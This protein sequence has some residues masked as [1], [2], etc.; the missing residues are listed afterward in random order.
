MYVVASHC[1]ICIYA[2]ILQYCILL[3]IAKC[4]WSVCIWYMTFQS[5]TVELADMIQLYYVNKLVDVDS[6][7][8]QKVINSSRFKRHFARYVRPRFMYQMINKKGKCLNILPFRLF[9]FKFKILS[10]FQESKGILNLIF[11]G[12]FRHLFFLLIIQ[13]IANSTNVAKAVKTWVSASSNRLW[14][15]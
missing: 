12:M 6:K 2:F 9:F 1:I 15:R 5:A 7:L 11:G 3:S 4:I 10:I 14:S 13:Y 8:K